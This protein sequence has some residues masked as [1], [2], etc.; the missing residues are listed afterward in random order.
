M[1][2]TPWDREFDALTSE[3]DVHNGQL[4]DELVEA[5]L[6]VRDGAWHHVLPVHQNRWPTPHPDR[7]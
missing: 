7:R 6:A 2:T 5:G 1:V 4:L 3:K